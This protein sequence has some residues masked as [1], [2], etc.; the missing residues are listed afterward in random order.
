MI[1]QDLNFVVVSPNLGPSVFILQTIDSNF[2]TIIVRKTQTHSVVYIF[3]ILNDIVNRYAYTE[4]HVCVYIEGQNHISDE[5]EG[6]TWPHSF[7]MHL[8][9]H[10]TS[11][12]HMGFLPT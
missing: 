3:L 11:F 2:S 6:V 8:L 10:A 7:C 4:V 12:G 1:K 9:A 5:G